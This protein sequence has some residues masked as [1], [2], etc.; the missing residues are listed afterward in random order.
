MSLDDSQIG[1]LC[2]LL[3]DGRPSVAAALERQIASFSEEDRERVLARLRGAGRRPAALPPS[4]LAFHARRLERDF[5][6]WIASPPGEPDLERGALLL[7][8]YADPLEDMG[9]CARALDEMG[10]AL[11]AR[12]AG[13]GDARERVLRTARF[14]HGEMGFAG[15]R[16]RYYDPENSYLHRVVE[17]RRGIP[18][19]LSVVY[20][21][22]GRR[23]GLR[24]EG[25]GMP[26]HCIVMHAGPEAPVYLDPFGGGRILE[27]ADC[28]AV[29]KEMGY[30]FDRRFLR[31][32]P[33]RRILERMLNNLIGIFRREGDEE[34]SRQLL[35]YR[36]I[37]QS[38]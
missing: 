4:L 37:V 34:R 12:L 36:E 23:A 11:R 7:A 15:D 5:A 38:G 18:I 21:L 10:G 29:V 27:E 28:A 2:T 25:G 20:I 33:A 19:S 9:R 13:A 17:R 32:T 24:L 26:G 14:L 3:E 16:E 31:E 8:S 35:R 22:L 30:H 1:A 6:E